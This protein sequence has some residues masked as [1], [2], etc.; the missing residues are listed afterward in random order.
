MFFLILFIFYFFFTFIY[1]F[2]Y[3]FIVVDFVIH[4]NETAM[5]LHVFPT[6]IPPPTSLST[7]SLWVFP[8]HQP[9]ALV[10]CIQPGLVISFTLDNNVAHTHGWGP[11]VEAEEETQGGVWFRKS[12]R[13]QRRRDW[14]GCRGRE[15]RALRVS[16]RLPCHPAATPGFHL[17]QREAPAPHVHCG[18][19]HSGA[20]GSPW[21]LPWGPPGVRTPHSHRQAGPIPGRG[22][23]SH[24]RATAET[25]HGQISK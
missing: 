7:W 5:G 11:D 2:I 25:Q 15:W 16:E 20:V 12:G 13:Q 8:V 21:G 22:T 6:P 14:R 24:S 23:R 3:F 10:S 4:W 9:R 19:Q 1:L 18:A 17:R